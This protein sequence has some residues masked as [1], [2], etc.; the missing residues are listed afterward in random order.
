MAISMLRL[1][2]LLEAPAD[3]PTESL[4]ERAHLDALIHQ[5]DD[6]DFRT[7]ERAAVGLRKIG[8]PALEPLKQS[9]A[10][11]KSSE[12]RE[13]AEKLAREIRLASFPPGKTMAGMRSTLRAEREVYRADELIVM[14]FEIEN[15]S[16][17]DLT[18]PTKFLWNYSQT[19]G[20][21]RTAIYRVVQPHHAKFE[22]F[23]LSG[24]KPKRKI[25]PIFLSCSETQSYQ[26]MKIGETI[27]Y[28][29][30]VGIAGR[31]LPG[32]YE[33]RAFVHMNFAV[34]GSKEYLPSNSVR[35]TIE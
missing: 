1:I 14:N 2:F 9:A 17:D 33:I 28:P 7:R 5:L 11:A 20:P 21:Q 29:V 34:P 18:L 32:E 26:K 35:F 16:N 13:R 15:V 24:R 19:Y 23:Q 8:T 12:V 4:I 27:Q 6:D 22:I 10:M 25:D 30:P 31:L 3:P